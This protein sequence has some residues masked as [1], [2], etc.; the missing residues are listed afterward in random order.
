MCDELKIFIG[1]IIAGHE[2]VIEVE[3]EN[4]EVT[5]YVEDTVSLL[6]FIAPP[7]EYMMSSLLGRISKA[8][9]S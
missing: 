1:G 8:Y 9:R 7:R 4:I 2:H 5:G 6:G 3:Q